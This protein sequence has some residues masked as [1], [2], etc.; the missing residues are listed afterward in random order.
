ML[1]LISVLAWSYAN[2]LVKNLPKMALI[3]ESYILPDS[4][5]RPVGTCQQ[6]PCLPDSK[7][8]E[9]SYERLTSYFPKESSEVRLTHMYHSSSFSDSNHIRQRMIHHFKQWFETLNVILLAAESIETD[10]HI[11]IV[12]H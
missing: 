6:G 11:R 7:M 4:S 1:D 8:V 3:A 12:V 5:Y 2:Q 10:A 9:V